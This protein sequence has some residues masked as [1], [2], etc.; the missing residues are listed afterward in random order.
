MKKSHRESLPA[1]CAERGEIVLAQEFLRVC[2]A[3]DT[4]ERAAS[5]VV[6]DLKPG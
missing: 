4:L 1:T 2:G 6:L 5:I 3:G